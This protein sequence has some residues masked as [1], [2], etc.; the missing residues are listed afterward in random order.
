MK[1]QISLIIASAL[2]L[3]ATLTTSCQKKSSPEPAKTAS[4]TTAPTATVTPTI[5]VEFF[6]NASTYSM[7]VMAAN[8]YL[9]P[10]VLK[11]S[12][13]FSSLGAGNVCTVTGEKLTFPYSKYVFELLQ[14]VLI[15]IAA[16]NFSL[17]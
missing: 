13:T 7:R 11:G 12:K 17:L 14:R 4:T 16:T 5:E 9:S 15:R 8:Q 3:T 10:A 1:K 6:I 2:M